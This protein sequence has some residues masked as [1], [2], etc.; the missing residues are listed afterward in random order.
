MPLI[1]I[2]LSEGRSPEQLRAL[3][4]HVHR[5]VR[6]AL[7][8]PADSI[9]VI[10]REVPPTHWSAGDVTLAERRPEECVDPSLPHSGVR[11]GP[12]PE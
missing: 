10:V 3:L 11:T 6:D 9:R 2:T 5:S 1:E 12:P 8:A 4:H 7:G